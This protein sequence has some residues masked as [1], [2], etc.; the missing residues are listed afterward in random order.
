MNR[1]PELTIANGPFVLEGTSTRLL[2]WQVVGALVPVVLVAGWFFGITAFLVVGT[3]TA[4][5]TL[6]ERAFATDRA[7]LGDGSAVL[8]G[9][10]LGL[11]LPPAIPLWMAALGG[12]CAIAM[13]KV[14][15]GGLGANLFNPALLGRAF[16]QAAFP[17]AM[18][19]W[20][21]PADGFWTLFPTTL[22]PPFLR[23]AEPIDAFTGA[24]PLGA[25]KFEGQLTEVADLFWGNIGGSLGETSAAVLIVCGLVLGFRRVFDWRAP[26]ATLVSVLFSATALHLLWPS[27]CPAPDFM[28]LAG[29]LLLG[30]VFMVTDPVT[31]PITPRGQWIFGLGLGFLIVLI[32][33]YGGLPEG[34]MFAI[35]F[36]NALTP[37]INRA[38][39]PRLFGG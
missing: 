37:L 7:S 28:L 14:I 20:V 15:W 39:Q 25:A 22:A 23:A 36:M 13:G 6:T 1:P 34:V 38:T 8:T 31:T 27:D 24:T 11:T 2:M 9:L 17:E 33:V 5:A 21:R 4:A 18:T 29:G 19:T 16:L 35:L 3:T 12:F 32:R 30:T 26:T 10:L